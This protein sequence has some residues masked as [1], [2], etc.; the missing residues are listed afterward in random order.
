VS[1]TQGPARPPL[2]DII[3]EFDLGAKRR[4]GQ[5]FLLDANL[6]RKIA[7]AAGD[8]GKGSVIEIGPGPGGLTRALLDAHAKRVIAV[9]LDPRCVAALEGLV[10]ESQGRLTIIEGDALTVALAEIAPPPRRIVANL[11]YNVATPLLL[12]WLAAAEHFEEMI[13]MFQKEVADRLCAKPG[14][15]A[16]GRLSIVAQWRMEI[17]PL[18][19]IGPKAFVPPPKVS[20]T[21][22]RLRTRAKPIA[23][24]DGAIDIV[25]LGRVTRAAF[26]QRRKMLRSSLK[27]LGIEVAAALLEETGISPTARAEELRV[28]DFCALARAL[29]RRGLAR[30]G[31]A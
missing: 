20:S 11:P 3:R 22:L 15:K 6:T 2:R 1:S 7:N 12:Q 16:Y 9:E 27:T 29:A 4:F 19:D 13:L 8:L 23:A 25:T 10:A 21:V 5:H 18:F 14:S 17:T 30:R 28:E 31:A 26:G 24:A